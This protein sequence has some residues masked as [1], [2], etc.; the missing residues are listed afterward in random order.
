MEIEKTKYITITIRNGKYCPTV[1]V[2]NQKFHLEGFESN[3]DAIFVG[4]KLS[5]ALQMDYKC[6]DVQQSIAE[7]FR[8][9]FYSENVRLGFSLNEII[10]DS[11][12]KTLKGIRNQMSLDDS[13][14]LQISRTV[15]DNDYSI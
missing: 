9:C 2:D 6:I 12:E 1:I 13:D 3:H 14:R 15:Q 5:E 8:A 11:I 4:R 7:T 10:N